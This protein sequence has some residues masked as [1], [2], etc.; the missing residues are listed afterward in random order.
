MEIQHDQ[1]LT[2]S[3][4]IPHEPLL[5]RSQRVYFGNWLR[6]YSQVRMLK[7]TDLENLLT[8]RGC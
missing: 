7:L 3:K 8:L 2:N 4:S 1:G 6:D 5:N